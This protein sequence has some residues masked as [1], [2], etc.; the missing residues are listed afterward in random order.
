MSDGSWV[1]R[2]KCLARIAPM[3]CFMYF[4][5]P[6]IW[7]AWMALRLGLVSLGESRRCLTSPATI[8]IALFLFALNMANL[9][10][11]AERIGAVADGRV[12]RR[13]AVHRASLL[14]FAAIGTTASMSALLGAQA[15]EPFPPRRLAVGALNGASMCFMFY[16]SS[17]AGAIAHLAPPG[18]R[19]S[20]NEREAVARTRAFNSCLFAIG[21]PLFIATSLVAARLDGDF[22]ADRDVIR[23]LASLALSVAMGSAL[24]L[25]ADKRIAA[26]SGAVGKKRMR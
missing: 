3:Y 7:Q 26:S 1:G 17:T 19:L 8:S 14:A 4:L 12:S 6:I 9:A 15:G 13:L 2:A 11:G 23:L 18:G 22:P 5:G 21:L 10:K 24:F 20:E 16:A 25:R